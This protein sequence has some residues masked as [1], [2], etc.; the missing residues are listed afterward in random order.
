MHTNTKHF[1]NELHKECNK[2]GCNLKEAKISNLPPLDEFIIG[3][4]YNWKGAIN[5]GN[6]Y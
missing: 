5:S 6:T 3:G 4:G 1:M 2:G